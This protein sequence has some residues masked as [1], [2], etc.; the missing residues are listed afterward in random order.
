MITLTLNEIEQLLCNPCKHAIA[1][2]EQEIAAELKQQQEAEVQRRQE[3][4]A[5]AQVKFGAKFIGDCPMCNE[6]FLVIRRLLARSREDSYPYQGCTA[7]GYA[8]R[9]AN[10]ESERQAN[11]ILAAADEW[12]RSGK[13]K[14]RRTNG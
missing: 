13:W 9:F 7:C 1:Q 4:R 14:E 6:G 3:D 10:A 5:K 12:I 11:Q 8:E 2:R